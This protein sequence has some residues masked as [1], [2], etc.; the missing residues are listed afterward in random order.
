VIAATIAALFRAR[1]R[2]LF[3]AHREELIQQAADKISRFTSLSVGIEMGDERVS[4][5]FMPDVVIASVQTLSRPN[6][7]LTFGPD[8]FA[9]I[10]VDESHHA[11]SVSYGK[12]FEYFAAAKLLGLTAT[13]DRS[14]GVGLGKV[15]QSVA[16]TFDIRSGIEQRYLA[17][18]RQQMVHVEGL[19]LSRIR[20]TAGDFNDGD[21]EKL[22][23]QEAHLHSVASPLAERASD[24]PTLVFCA[25]VAHAHALAAVL[26]RYVGHQ[27]VRALDGTTD[28]AVRRQAIEAFEARRFQFLVNCAL[29]TEGFDA[30]LTS[31]VAVAK[32]TTSRALYTQ[33]VGRG[34]RLALGKE[35]LLVLN[36]VGHAGN[37]CLINT[38]DILGGDADP[39]VRE[40]ALKIITERPEVDVLS[41]LDEAARVRESARQQV[42][43]TARYSTVDVNPFE[44]VESVLGIKV[45]AG[46]GVAATAAQRDALTQ[47]G[48]DIARL[49]QAQAMQL[50][51]AL[52]DRRSRKLCTYK[53]AQILVRYG[54]DPN[55]TFT[56]ASR[57]IDRIARNGWKRPTSQSATEANQ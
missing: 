35:D 32:P 57:A 15:F 3:I 56:E 52:N 13:P 17:P 31:C 23:T 26:G 27:N 51:A 50:L 9:L 40:R 47:K 18:I 19:D 5:L 42:V 54:L 28:R 44:K 21:L 53:Q 20:I 33:I 8:A 34:T 37:H 48:I 55:L 25:T 22:L 11:P 36:F 24:R 16:F 7:L 29:F 45:G 39:K 43:A 4:P 46:N 12:I 10:I 30:P 41:A 14:D 38:A 1:G 6:R 49:D 2:I